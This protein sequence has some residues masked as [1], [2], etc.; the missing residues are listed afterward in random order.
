M[1]AMSATIDLLLPGMVRTCPNNVP[2]CN[3]WERAIHFAKHGHK[4]GASDASEYE[5]MAEVFMYGPLNGDGHECIRPQ[6]D[7]VRFGFATHY[8]GVTRTAPAPECIRTFYPVELTTIARR[9][10]E[11]AYFR[12][13]CRRSSGV[14]L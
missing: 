12:F 9:G 6:G 2:Y 11:A 5:R 13:E 8:E 3:S 10:G 4:F 7:R 14:D 1:S